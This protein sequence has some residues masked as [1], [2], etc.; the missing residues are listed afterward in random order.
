MIL[1]PDLIR[2]AQ[3]YFPPILANPVNPEILSKVLRTAK[4]SPRLAKFSPLSASCT[5]STFPNVK[6]FHTNCDSDSCG[7]RRC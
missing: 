6:R 5:G 1:K 2:N 4:L 7:K 3:I